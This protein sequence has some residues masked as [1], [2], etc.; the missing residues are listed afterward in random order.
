MEGNRKRILHK[1]V[2]YCLLGTALVVVVVC[3]CNETQK[4][5]NPLTQ[6][7]PIVNPQHGM[8]R[9]FDRMVDNAALGDMA[10][11]DVHFMPHRA[12]LN[13]LGC[14]QL[15]R[16]VW[17]IQNYG[18][19][20]ILD[21]EQPQSELAAQRQQ[22]VHDYLLA[23]GLANDAIGITMGLP[24]GKGLP[25]TEAITIYKDTRYKSDK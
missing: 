25:A 6:Q 24:K 12:Y 15:S 3:G 13:S 8:N 10:I 22:I 16:L 11:S 5:K 2:R 7:Q 17:V 21:L 14:K 1:D 20:V 23:C 4:T 19:Q 18:G 9:Q